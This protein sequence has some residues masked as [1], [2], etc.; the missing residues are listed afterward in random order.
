MLLMLS[1]TTSFSPNCKD[2]DS[3]AGHPSMNEEKESMPGGRFPF[4]TL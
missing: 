4:V 2:M 1:P 3:M